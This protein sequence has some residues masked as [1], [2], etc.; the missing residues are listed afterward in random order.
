MNSDIIGHSLHRNTAAYKHVVASM[1]PFYS[2]ILDHGHIH[3]PDRVY[4]TCLS[5]E[6]L[7]AELLGF[8]P[9]GGVHMNGLMNSGT[10]EYGM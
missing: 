6:P 7:R 8:V 9:Q 5:N 4:M 2:T 3:C 10:N 1:D